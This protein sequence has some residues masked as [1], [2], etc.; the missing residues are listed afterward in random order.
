MLEPIIEGIVQHVPFDDK[1]PC[2]APEVN[3]IEYLGRTGIARDQDDVLETLVLDIVQI[4]IS[5]LGNNVTRRHMMLLKPSEERPRIDR[6][7]ALE[8]DLTCYKIDIVSRKETQ[9]LDDADKESLDDKILYA[10][11]QHIVMLAIGLEK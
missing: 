4:E 8:I 6:I 5:I 10:L 9:H 2:M 7:K 1:G 3:V 11:E